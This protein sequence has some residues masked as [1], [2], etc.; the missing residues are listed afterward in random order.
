[1]SSWVTIPSLMA[2]RDEFN[3]VSPA[4][5][6]GADGTIG[7]TSHSSSSD[8]TPDE[9]SSVLRNKDADHIN[10]VHALDIDSTGPWPD[11]R[12]GEAGG[13]FD[14]K[15]K[16]IIAEEKR[17]WM[18]PNDMCRL[19]YVIW[20]G[21]IYDKDADWAGKTYTA[22]SDK[23]YNHA[24]FSARYETKAE[25]DVRS[26]GV[27]VPPAPPSSQGD[28]VTTQAEFN[29]LLA[30]AINTIKIPDF[31]DPNTPDRELTLRQWIGYSEGRGQINELQEELDEVK[32][33][34]ASINAN[35][36]Q[37]LNLLQPPVANKASSATK[38]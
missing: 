33:Q 2:L 23:H 9:D 5:D 26:W 17:R 25:R 3:L 36:T 11:G 19:N 32:G 37:I 1:M 8:H 4:R 21:V 16:A 22:S 20:R 10:E 28:L 15:I 7:D 12:G 38:S 24:H 18:D 29:S 31:A 6:K 35:L 13:W 14:K 30:N 34:I 27:Y